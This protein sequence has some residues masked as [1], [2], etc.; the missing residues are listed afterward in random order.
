MGVCETAN[1]E[2]I[3]AN[4]ESNLDYTN[5]C[6]QPDS[7]LNPIDPSIVDA[8]KSL[9]KIWIPS[10]N[11]VSSGFLIK[12]V[13]NQEYFFC[14]VTNEHVISK[15]MI[16]QQ[17][18]IIISYDNESKTRIIKLN[19]DER[20]IKEFTDFTMD[21]TFVEILPKDNISDDYL[22]LTPTE[23]MDNLDKLIGKEITIVQ[24]PKGKLH[25]NKKNLILDKY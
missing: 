13:K 15:E 16:E 23:H 17:E 19:P 4:Q 2:E 7:S 18:T 10:I 12:F 11:R 1:K 21:V 8:L 22:K 25:C 3:I 24:Y 6:Y 9:C 20:C 5:Q 14:L